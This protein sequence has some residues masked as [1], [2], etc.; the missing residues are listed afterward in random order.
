M[1]GSERTFHPYVFEKTSDIS[2]LNGVLR[3]FVDEWTDVE[4]DR[5]ANI[6]RSASITCYSCLTLRISREGNKAVVRALHSLLGD[7]NSQTGFERK[8]DLSQLFSV[9]DDVV[10][11]TD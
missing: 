7:G 11:A 4:K 9:T 6:G 8:F 5:K 3:T 2:E 1:R 10:L